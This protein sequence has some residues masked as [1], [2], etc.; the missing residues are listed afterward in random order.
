MERCL[1]KACL[2][3]SAQWAS[4]CLWAV[5]LWAISTSLRFAD[6]VRWGCVFPRS[7]YAQLTLSSSAA[8]DF[9]SVGRLQA[10]VGIAK[11][12]EKQELYSAYSWIKST[13]D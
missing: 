12:Q 5:C 4:V 10:M 6:S 7:A 2:E 1:A 3:E 9:G 8:A 13:C 11:F